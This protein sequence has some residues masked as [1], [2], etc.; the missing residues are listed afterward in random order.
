[1][2]KQLIYVFS[3]TLLDIFGPMQLIRRCD[4]YSGKYGYVDL[5]VT[6]MEFYLFLTFSYLF[7]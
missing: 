7:A 1:M 5:Y 2:A 4:L 6:L 3:S